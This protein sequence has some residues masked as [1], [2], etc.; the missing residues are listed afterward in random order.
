MASLPQ[1]GGRVAMRARYT[2]LLMETLCHLLSRVGKLPVGALRYL[3]FP[4]EKTRFE[5]IAADILT[6][7]SHI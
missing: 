4:D 2:L 5:L 1:N 6:S 7:S 3:P